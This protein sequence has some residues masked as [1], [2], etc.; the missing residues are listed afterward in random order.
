M[1]TAQGKATHLGLGGLSSWVVH[2]GQLGVDLLG[3]MVV[4]G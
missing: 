1:E 3:V 2:V 4:L